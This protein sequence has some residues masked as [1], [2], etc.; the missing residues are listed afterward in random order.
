MLFDLCSPDMLQ[1]NSMILLAVR[2][3]GVADITGSLLY[4]L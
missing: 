4:E 2:A 3:Y 1:C